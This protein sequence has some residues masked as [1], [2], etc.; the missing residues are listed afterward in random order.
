MRPILLGNAWYPSVDTIL[1][2]SP[3]R[4]HLEHPLKGLRLPG[5]PEEQEQNQAWLHGCGPEQSWV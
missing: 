1:E 5:R 3:L 2:A 4:R